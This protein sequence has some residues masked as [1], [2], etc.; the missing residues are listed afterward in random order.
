MAVAEPQEYF[1]GPAFA[2]AAA[3]YEDRKDDFEKAVTGL[4]LNGIHSKGM[5][6]LFFA[7]V[8][9]KFWALERLVRLGANPLQKD[10]DLGTPIRCAVIANDPKLLSAFLGGGVDPGLRSA[11]G[12]PIL[13]DAACEGYEPTL[14]LLLAAG[15]DPSATDKLGATAALQAFYFRKFDHVELLIRSGTRVDLCTGRGVTLGYEVDQFLSRLPPDSPAYPKVQEIRQLLANRGVEFPAE[16]PE[17]LRRT[18]N[19]D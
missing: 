12:T 11:D 6:L 17:A 8:N 10:P 7:L 14:K 1:T 18:P 9:K 4:E 15:A 3:I 2:V 19:R 13:F 16:P 5:T